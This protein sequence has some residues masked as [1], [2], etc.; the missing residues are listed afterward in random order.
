MRHTFQT[1]QWLPYPIELVFAFF[2]NPENLPHLMPKW[3]KARIEEMRLIPPPARP[4][5]ADPRWRFKSLAAGAGS[6]MTI[7]FKPFPYAP[8]RLPW[9]ARITEF[10]WN[11]HFCDEQ[12]RGPLAYWRHCHSVCAESREGIEGTL[13]RDELEYEMKFGKLGEL[14]H[15]PIFAPQ[16]EKI[17]AYRQRRLAEILSGLHARFSR[18]SES[19]SGPAL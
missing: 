6:V 10:V 11:S 18:G 4:A 1:E 12:I 2:A 17:F 15:G 13:I 7:S 19:A 8:T 16:V 9:E 5:P 14:A 3:Q